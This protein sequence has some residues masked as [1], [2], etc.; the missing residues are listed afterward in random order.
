MIMNYFWCLC[1]I[2]SVL[3]AMI[4]GQ[5]GGITTSFMEGA[6]AAVTLA[7]TM[8]GPLC[9]WSGLGNLMEKLSIT[10]YP[11]ALLRPVLYKLFPSTRYDPGISRAIS[12]NVC[13]NLL[14][15]GNAA[16]PMGIR[17]VSKLVN[18]AK[19]YTA[20]DEMCR[21]V[22][23]NTASIQ[24]LPTT[25]AAVRAGAGCRNP[26]DILPCV[27]ISSL[28]SVSAGLLAAELLRRIWTDV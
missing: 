26:L 28:L 12:A 6:T 23:M 20:T 11:T 13:A 5:V 19:P 7:I 8:A 25:V 14:G 21:L 15:L 27:W 1:V 9:L 3:F 10:D 2:L 18:P 22:V 16:T 17:A 24:L 4:S